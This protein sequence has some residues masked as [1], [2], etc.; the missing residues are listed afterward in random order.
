MIVVGGQIAT[1]YPFVSDGARWSV[2]LASVMEWPSAVE[3]NIEGG[4]EDSA[5]CV[6]DT[7]YYEWCRVYRERNPPLFDYVVNAIAYRLEPEPKRDRETQKMFAHDFYAY[8]PLTVE[9]AAC[10]EIQFIS[11]VEGVRETHFLDTMLTVYTIRLGHPD[12]NGRKL[13]LFTPLAAQRKQFKVGQ[14]VTGC[15]WMF[16]YAAA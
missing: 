4:C 1:V 16:G 10:D 7:L 8:L 6:F 2:R 11:A 12:Y 5:V 13:D 15:G 14:R 9:G 3:A